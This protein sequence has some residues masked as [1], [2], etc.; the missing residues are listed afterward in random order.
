MPHQD[1][2]VR[3]QLVRSWEV[4]GKVLE[5]VV[6]DNSILDI[7]ES[8]IVGAVQVKSASFLSSSPSG[9]VNVDRPGMKE[10]RYVTMPKNSWIQ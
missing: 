3:D 6:T 1:L 2:S 10:L 7:L 8:G 5:G 4:R 9:A